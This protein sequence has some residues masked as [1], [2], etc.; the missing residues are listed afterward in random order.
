LSRDVEQKKKKLER[1]ITDAQENLNAEQQSLLE[2]LSQKMLAL[3]G[4]YAKDNG[5]IAVFDEGNPNSPI[6]Y[7]SP[8][9]DITQDL[10]AVFDKASETSDK[11]PR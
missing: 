6:L 1:D 3:I 4:K 2:S 8:A 11:K 5:Y 10:I 9:I 7:A